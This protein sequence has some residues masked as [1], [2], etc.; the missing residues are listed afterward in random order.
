MWMAGG[1]IKGGTVF[2]ST[3]LID[4]I[5]VDGN[6]DALSALGRELRKLQCPWIVG[7]D[8]NIDPEELFD[9]GFIELMRG[10][11]VARGKDEGTCRTAGGK[12]SNID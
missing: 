8:W 3:Y 11:I 12:W 1:G 9:S 4:S 7:G 5:G 10:S 6:R 2:G